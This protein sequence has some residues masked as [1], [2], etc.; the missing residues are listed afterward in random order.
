MEGLWPWRGNACWL[1]SCRLS[2]ALLEPDLAPN[3]VQVS[4]VECGPYDY[5]R[6]GNPTRAQLEAHM[7]DLEAR[8]CFGQLLSPPNTLL[9]RSPCTV[10]SKEVNPDRTAPQSECALLQAQ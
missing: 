6:S 8:A 4:A 3:D 9:C 2:H 10:Y 7:A 1:C 5:S